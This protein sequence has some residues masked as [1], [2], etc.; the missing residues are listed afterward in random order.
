MGK[1]NITVIAVMFLS[2]RC[3]IVKDPPQKMRAYTHW[4]D[5]SPG[6][7]DAVLQVDAQA[8]FGVQKYKMSC[9]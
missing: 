4:H 2:Q 3:G 7:V 9:D 8:R 1:K 6:D 5:C